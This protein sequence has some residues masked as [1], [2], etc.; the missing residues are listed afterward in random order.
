MQIL[1]DDV[2]GEQ[3]EIRQILQ[4]RDVLCLKAKFLGQPTIVRNVLERARDK[5]PQRGYL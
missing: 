5:R 3:R 2:L 1:A 4:R